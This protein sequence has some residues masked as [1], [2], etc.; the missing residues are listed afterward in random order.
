MW[1]IA[2]KICT[3]SSSEY[4]VKWP[5]ALTARACATMLKVYVTTNPLLLCT[6]RSPTFGPA[7]ICLKTGPAYKL[8]AKLL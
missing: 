6:P 2:L 7:S 4:V 3:E 8:G 5:K 1:P